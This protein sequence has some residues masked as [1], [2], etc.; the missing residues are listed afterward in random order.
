MFPI[1]FTFLLPFFSMVN[2]LADIFIHKICHAIFKIL[3]VQIRMGYT[4]MKQTL[5]LPLICC[6]AQGIAQKCLP[7]AGKASCTFQLDF[8]GLM[9]EGKRTF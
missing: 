3:L 5:T 9:E 7:F 2:L 1:Q 8:K 6:L 4:E